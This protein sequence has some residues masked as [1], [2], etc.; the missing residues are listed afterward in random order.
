MEC[1]DVVD[2][3]S[4]FLDDELDPVA[5]Q[6]VSRHLDSC[7]DCAA[8]LERQ[9]QLSESLRRDLEYHRAPDLLRARVLPMA[10]AT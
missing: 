1:R 3:L 6:E 7:P 4:P 2:R 9:R 8:D 10:Q 5:S